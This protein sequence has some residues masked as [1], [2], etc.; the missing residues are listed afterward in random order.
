MVS[1][2][3]H[4]YAVCV[5]QSPTDERSNEIPYPTTVE[6]IFVRGYGFYH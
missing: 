3:A 6:L 2:Y 1:A 5:A 4:E